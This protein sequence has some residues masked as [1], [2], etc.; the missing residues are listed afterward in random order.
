[1]TMGPSHP[2]ARSNIH[3]YVGVVR[4]LTAWLGRGRH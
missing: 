1:M 3:A 2:S 4:G